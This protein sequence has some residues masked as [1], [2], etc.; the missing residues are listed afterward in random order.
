MRRF[1]GFLLILR[2][3]SPFLFLVVLGIA[4][5]LVL[6]DLRTELQPPIQTIQDELGKISTIAEQT[7]E[8]F[9]AVQD[10]V[11]DLVSAL[12]AFNPAN[13]IPDISGVINIP[14]LTIPDVTIPIPDVPNGVSISFSSINIAGVNLSY[15]SGISIGTR[16]FTLTIP[17]ISAFN[18]TIPGLDLLGDAIEA[19]LAPIADIFDVFTPTFESINELNETLQQVP[20]SFET[21]TAEGEALV[22][23]VGD[24]IARWSVTLT[25]VFVV[26]ALLTVIYF[27]V[28][29][30]D[31]F[32]RGLQMLRGLPAD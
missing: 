29:F 1:M 7:Q 27:G 17:D 3:L 18:I 2:A 31:A 14:A 12:E 32:H 30:L 21:I 15:P 5:L 28:P 20:Q 19:A 8:D 9:E 16:N 10:E 24:V 6:Q 23:D 22:K 4:G 25:I 11:T 26:L 13:L